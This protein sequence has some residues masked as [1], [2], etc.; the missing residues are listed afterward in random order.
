MRVERAT[1]PCLDAETIAAFAEGRVNRSKIREVVAHLDV[2]EACRE[3]VEAASEAILEEGIS[4]HESPA[5]RRTWWLAVAAAIVVV[6][7]AIPAT[8]TLIAL[9]SPIARLASMSPRDE[10]TI[11]PRLAGGFAWAPYRG[12]L[13]A[14]DAAATSVRMKLTGAAGEL[15]DRADREPSAD[16]QHAAGVALALAGQNP[17]DAIARLRAA[18]KSLPDDAKAWS[19]LAAAEYAAALARGA[20]SQ[21][22]V[23]LADADHALR[24]DP[25][26]PEALFNRAL[27]L[28]H[29]GLI[30]QTRAAWERYLAVDGTSAWASEA[31]ERLAKLPTV[32]GDAQFKHELPRLVAA[33]L[34]GDT[35]TV[36]AI[37]RAFPQ[38]ARIEG[39][40]RLLAEWGEA[41]SK[42]DVPSADR[43]LTVARAIGDALAQFSGETMLRDSVKRID[44][45]TVARRPDMAAGHALIA[46]GRALSKQQKAGEA[47]HLM[48]EAAVKFAAT[49]DPMALT[50]RF[51]AAGARLAQNDAA[52]ARPELEALMIAV[53]TTELGAEVRWELARCH[54]FDD[55]WAA[56]LPLLDEAH[57]RFERL[58]ER[59][60]AG[61]IDT[62][63]SSVLV[64]L[65]RADEAWEARSRAFAAL[66][67][68][69]RE[70]RL[71]GSIDGAAQFE[72][73]AGRRDTALA[74]LGL[75][76]EAQRTIATPASIAAMFVQKT[77][78]N[79]VLG[80][81]DAALHSA[82][83]AEAVA[84]RVSDPALRTR[85]VADAHFA[86]A[87][88]VLERDPRRARELL[89]SAIDGY[90]RACRDEARRWE[91]RGQRSRR[92]HRRGGT[93][94][95][96]LRR[97]GRGNGRAQCRRRA[98]RGCDPIASRSRR[99]GRRVRVCGARARRGCGASVC[100]GAERVAGHGRARAAS[101]RKRR[102]GAGARRSA[103]RSRG[104]HRHRT[105][106]VGGTHS[107]RPRVPC[108]RAR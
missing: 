34:A 4:V 21:I 58:G 42:N 12:P 52:H 28:D 57:A 68:E 18:A 49:G 102:G 24:I 89:T 86:T 53:T 79:V 85:A 26:M 20:A 66:S 25:R 56:A 7:L 33:A 41:V 2:C 3:A 75:D 32:T 74:L 81:H 5:M 39:E 11:E 97:L 99:R 96:P 43:S 70:D 65:G 9:R 103:R 50:A 106:L 14:T 31:R 73:R 67:R 10:R 8:R 17:D 78:L 98:V 46:R 77:L 64:S 1:S 55:D 15:V 94:A 51:Y 92:R 105:R 6:I 84:L 16:A 36:A 23:A 62:I 61:F 59:A 100:R 88:V 107:H 45:A 54:T 22:P 35:H 108:G 44:G 27:I 29:L 47:E 80:N 71:A 48:R 82:R 90:P 38:Q 13:R 30:S 40:Q 63:R 93:L 95:H 104:V 19:D 83:D 91:C 69:G 60:N 87:A 76:E 37:V 72:L 101:R